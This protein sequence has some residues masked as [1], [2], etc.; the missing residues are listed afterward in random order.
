MIYLLFLETSLPFNDL[1]SLCC[2]AC[3]LTWFTRNLNFFLLVFF[4]LSLSKKKPEYASYNTLDFLFLLQS[5]PHS[6]FCPAAACLPCVCSQ[7]SM[8]QP[9]FLPGLYPKVYGYLSVL[10]FIFL[11]AADKIDSLSSLLFFSQTLVKLSSSFFPQS[12]L[13]SFIHKART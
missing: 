7:T 12:S 6:C 10:F 3:P 2:V 5:S 11:L 8:V 4:F 13:N 9:A 1:F